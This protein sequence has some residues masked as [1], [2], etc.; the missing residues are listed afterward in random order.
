V[1]GGRG[2]RARAVLAVALA[3]TQLWF[4]LRYFRLAIDFEPGLSWL[5]LARDLALVA[6]TALLAVSLGRLERAHSS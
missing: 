1:R 5:L 3:L 2:L 4:P 6:V